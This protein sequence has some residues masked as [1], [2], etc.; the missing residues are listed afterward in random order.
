MYCHCID[1]LNQKKFGQQDNIFTHLMR[2]GFTK[3]YMCWNKHGEEGLNEIEAGCLNEG[4]APHHDQGLNEGAV[5]CHD[6]VV[7]GIYAY[8]T[9]FGLQA[10]NCSVV[11]KGP[12]F[13]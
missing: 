10:D 9:S 13:P 3:N 4:E 2:R 7:D 11:V 6:E 5:R 12:F 1:C 8:Q